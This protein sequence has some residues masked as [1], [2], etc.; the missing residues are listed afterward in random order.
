MILKRSTTEIITE[1]IIKKPTIT[2][3]YHISCDKILML[4]MGGCL[5]GDS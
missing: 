1:K 5:K 4:R 2:W 3:I